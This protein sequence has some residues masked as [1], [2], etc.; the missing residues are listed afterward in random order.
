[1]PAFDAHAYLGA[2]PFSSAMAYREAVLHTMQRYDID[3]VALISGLAANCDFVAGNSQLREVLDPA[4]GL[5]GYLTLNAGYPTESLEEQRRYLTRPEFVG[6]VLFGHGDTPVTADTARDILNAHRRY[7]KPMAVHVPDLAAVQAMR[8]IAT[9]FPAMKF[10][11][12]TMG[13]EDW[14]A[15]IVA[16]KQHLN[17]YVEISGS[18]DS[19][20]VAQAAAT[21]TPRKLL[22]GSGLPDGDPSLTLG[23]VAE[24]RGLTN[25]DRAR[26]LSQNAQGLFNLQSGTNVQSEPAE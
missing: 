10:V 6:G 14:H 20:K 11:L 1:M 21:L 5:Y 2:T 8:Q 23:L 24:A 18:R 16:A 25:F 3:G 15:A 4:S 9:E 19:D 17:M 13:G 22:F 12:L 7:S 26:I